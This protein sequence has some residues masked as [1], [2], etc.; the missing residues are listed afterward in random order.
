MDLEN[1]TIKEL[2]AIYQEASRKEV[3]RKSKLGLWKDDKRGSFAT[4][5]KIAVIMKNNLK[6]RRQAK[7]KEFKVLEDGYFEK[8]PINTLDE[9][10]AQNS[11]EN[12]K[13]TR[14]EVIDESGRV[15]VNNNCKIEL[16]YQDAGR[17]LKVFVKK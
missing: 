11:Q 10:M 15:Y 17:T 8:P 14:F 16:S 1:K 2:E 6:K 7:L 12:N 9:V 4:K 13:I 3:S 5:R